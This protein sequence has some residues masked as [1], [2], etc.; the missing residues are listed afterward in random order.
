[1]NNDR[2]RSAI[3]IWFSFFISMCLEAVPWPGL[4]DVMR[5]SWILLFLAYWVMALPQRISIGT[6]FFLGLFWDLLIGSDLGIHALSLSVSAYL[7][8]HYYQLLRNMAIWQQATIIALLS[9]VVKALI[10]WA[11]NIVNNVIFEPQY[12][13]GAVLNAVL[14]PWLY[15]LLRRVRRS[16]YIQ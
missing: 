4:L 16:F 14:W 15:F 13:W 9:I 1:M 7:I 6:A 5:P 10:F 11:E 2:L 3:I 12:L 8:G